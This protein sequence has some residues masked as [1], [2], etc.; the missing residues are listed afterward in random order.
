V[1]AREGG[2][3]VVCVVTGRSGNEVEKAVAD[4]GP[5]IAQNEN[6]DRGMGSSIRVGVNAITPVSAV[7]LLACDQLAVDE[8]TIRSLIQ[9]HEQTGRVIVASQYAGTLGIPALFDQS[10]FAELLSLPDDRGAKA[11]IQS[12]AARVAHFDFPDGALDLDS[13]E[14]LQAWRM[15]ANSLPTAPRSKF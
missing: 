7:V 3:D 9:V 4:L 5:L 13:P 11:V 15:R 2:C 1:R 10:C 14:D 8:D 6:W 12:D